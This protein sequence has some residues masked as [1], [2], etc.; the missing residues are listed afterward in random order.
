MALFRTRSSSDSKSE[1]TTRKKSATVDTVETLRTKA[2]Q[3]LI[4]SALLLL[5]G[6]ITFTLLFDNK[7]R[8]IPSDIEIII[9]DKDK[10]A[11]ISTPIQTPTQAPAQSSK[12]TSPAPSAST[13]ATDVRSLQRPATGTWK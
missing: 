6:I 10:L 11:P 13:A 2:R 7:P 3:R 5:A 1:P 8:P 12:P 9:P 4:G